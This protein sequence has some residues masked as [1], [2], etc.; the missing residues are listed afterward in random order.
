M[1]CQKCDDRGAV[2]VMYRSED[3]CDVGLCSCATGM[4]LRRFIDGSPQ[5][6]EKHFNLPIERIWPLEELVTEADFAEPPAGISRSV[7][8]SAGKVDRAGLGGKVTRK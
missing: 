4:L 3:P 1:L 5:A 6:L 2:R 8:L 7:L